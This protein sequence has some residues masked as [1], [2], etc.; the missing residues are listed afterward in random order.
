MLISAHTPVFPPKPD[1]ARTLLPYSFHRAQHG[2]P[3]PLVFGLILVI[4]ASS[5]CDNV[6]AATPNCTIDSDCG[7]TT[8][9]IDGNCE[10]NGADGDSE[11][12]DEPQADEPESAIPSLGVN[13]ARTGHH[14]GP[15]VADTPGIQWTYSAEQTIKSAPAVVDDTVFF[16]SHDNHLYAVSIKS[17]DEIWTLETGGSTLAS[18]RWT[19]PTVG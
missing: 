12:D 19:R 9:C 15:P 8:H 6:R 10:T 18:M 2:V 14:P 13:V 5:G 11:S 7:D 17:G 16:G 1:T 3:L 4:S